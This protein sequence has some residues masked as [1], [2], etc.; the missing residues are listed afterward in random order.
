M[1]ED[2]STAGGRSA[3]HGG[4]GLVG[5]DK[6]LKSFN[7]RTSAGS[8]RSMQMLRLA[9]GQ[10]QEMK[11]ASISPAPRS[12]IKGRISGMR[13]K[14]ASPGGATKLPSPG[15]PPPVTP[16]P[17][18]HAT[19]VSGKATSS[20][21]VLDLMNA[22]RSSPSF[23]KT[24]RPLSLKTTP[25]PSFRPEM[26]PHAAVR[27]PARPDAPT[28][29]KSVDRIVS[30]HSTRGMLNIGNTCYLAAVVQALKSMGAFVAEVRESESLFT[31]WLPEHGIIPSFVRFV[32][33]EKA[34][35][36]F[37]HSKSA[38]FNPES[39]KKAIAQ[40]CPQFD[41]SEQ[42]DAHEFFCALLDEMQQEFYHSVLSRHTP[43]SR[44]I[45]IGRSIEPVSRCFSCIIEHHLECKNCR[46]SSRVQELFSNLSLHLPH[47]ALASP[48]GFQMEKLLEG[49]FQEDTVDKECEHCS[50]RAFTVRHK[51]RR[52]PR[53]LVLHVKRFS[54]DTKTLRPEKRHDRVVAPLSLSL[55]SLCRASVKPPP[56]SES[57]NDLAKA[58]RLALSPSRSILDGQ[59]TPTDTPEPPFKRARLEQGSVRD[60]FLKRF[61]ARQERG[62]ASPLAE[63]LVNTPTRQTIDLL[64][65]G[66][67]EDNANMSE[68]RQLQAAIKASLHEQD[69][70]VKNSTSPQIR[71]C[72]RVVD[73]EL[74]DMD[75]SVEELREGVDTSY[76]LHSVVCHIGVSASAGHF[77]V[78]MVENNRSGERSWIRCDDSAV[79][80]LPEDSHLSEKSQ[81]EGYMYF[82]RWNGGA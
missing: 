50:G 36:S 47:A 4:K 6:K 77:V 35:L 74:D 81:R 58:F 52:L 39:I 16:V 32:A 65:D 21:S 51:I 23:A 78:D 34:P 44:T 24:Y 57:F 62:L 43:M 28:A 55:M 1:L 26:K 10:Q 53:V 30:T 7:F 66:E 5:A 60:E 14:E 69:E 70:K 9:T 42:Q 49:F 11:R 67:H 61:H 68:E 80:R 25:P 59:S 41:G 18:G 48:D 17:S 19:P 45:N 63:K 73:D 79:R 75:D 46:T 82:Y 71:E 8:R 2:S 64:E 31:S 37:T 27:I 13:P 12:V 76:T 29:T 72:V 3:P 15:P 38:A 54:I 40:N 22:S 20:V 33:A 56:S